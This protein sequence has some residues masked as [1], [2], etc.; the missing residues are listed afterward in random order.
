M[1]AI[2]GTRCVDRSNTLNRREKLDVVSTENPDRIAEK[3]VMA[4]R[5]YQYR[6]VTAIAP[7]HSVDQLSPSRQASKCDRTKRI[8]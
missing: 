3:R 4:S 6:A 2:G 8:G 7:N 5:V 1:L